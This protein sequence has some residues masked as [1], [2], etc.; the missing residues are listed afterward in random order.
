MQIRYF[1]IYQPSGP[2]T[3]PAWRS[4]NGGGAAR[5]SR[6][7]RASTAARAQ[8]AGGPIRGASVP[9]V[10]YRSICSSASTAMD[11]HCIARRNASLDFHVAETTPHIS[12]PPACG[13]RSR[14]IFTKACAAG[15]PCRTTRPRPG[16]RTRAPS[17]RCSGAARRLSQC[18]ARGRVQRWHVGG[19]QAGVNSR[20]SSWDASRTACEAAY[21]AQPAPPMSQNV[22]QDTC[23]LLI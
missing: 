2:R 4:M 23:K 22:G 17:S 1:L 8:S 13:W 9:E 21:I 10:R 12:R 15:P 11:C 19:G 5:P 7:L 3:T 18:E 14:A 20:T 16:P 6:R